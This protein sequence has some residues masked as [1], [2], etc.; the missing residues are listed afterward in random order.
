MK[1]LRCHVGRHT[2]SGQLPAGTPVDP[3]QDLLACRRCGQVAE[4][5]VIG[6]PTGRL[7]PALTTIRPAL[8]SSEV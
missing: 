8:A 5:S 3:T 4:A 7:G 2:W 1:S 6:R